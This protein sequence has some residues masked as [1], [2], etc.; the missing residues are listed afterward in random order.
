MKKMM[1]VMTL[2]VMYMMA[3]GSANA[4]FPPPPDCDPTCPWVR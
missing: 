3:V 4:G 1:M 2:A